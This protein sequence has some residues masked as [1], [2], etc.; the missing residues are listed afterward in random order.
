MILVQVRDVYRLLV[1]QSE[2]VRHAAAQLV[3]QVLEDQGCRFLAPASFTPS[4]N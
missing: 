2:A 3:A 1:D 4:L